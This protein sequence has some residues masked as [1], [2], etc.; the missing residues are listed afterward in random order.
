AFATH[1]GV[2][3]QN[4]NIG[5]GIDGLLGLVVRLY[6]GPGDKVLSS[7][8]AYPTFNYHVHGFG[9]QLITVPYRDDHE[10]LDALL[11]AAERERPKLV[12]LANPDNPMGTW[13]TGEAVA[14]FA[15]AL[16]SECMLIL[17]EAYCETAPEGTVPHID[18][19]TQNVL[20][21][22]TLSKAYGLAGARIGC[23][24][25]A[26]EA[27]QAFNKVRNHFGMNRISHAA[28]IAALKDQAYLEHAINSIAASRAR[29]AAI[30][31][32]NGLKP[33]PSATNFVTIDCGRDAAFAKLVLDGLIER[34]IF[35]RK[36]ATPVLDRCIRVSC[37]P[38][39]VMDLFEAALPD[40]LKAANA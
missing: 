28:G 8:G 22:R 12:Y 21:F 2:P 36:P 39:A 34:D 23:V 18:V 6:A 32:A 4:V 1:L 3:V 14:A 15:K 19:N 16:P 31:R 10:D 30:A 35:V 24:F 13:H 38:E 25:G 7:L 26:I 33:I 40:A 20:R 27:V 37:G 11:E 17:D 5:G 9:A 29:L